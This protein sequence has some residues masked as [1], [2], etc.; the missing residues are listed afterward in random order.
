MYMH[1]LLVS[2]F[3]KINPHG[4]CLSIYQKTPGL[5]LETLTIKLLPGERESE[6]DVNR[7]LSPTDR[8]S[9]AGSGRR[10]P[11]ACPGEGSIPNVELPFMTIALIANPSAGGR[12]DA[13][14]IPHVEGQLRRHRIDYRI[15]ITQ[16]HAHAI[17]IARK[18]HRRATMASCL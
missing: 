11:A 2:H 15:F 10:F 17:D 16:Y 1:V 12:K 7:G 6:R 9:P 4:G 8:P 13:R 5:S 14:M 3:Y 18:L